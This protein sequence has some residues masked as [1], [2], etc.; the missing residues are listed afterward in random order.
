MNYFRTAI[1][2]AG[3]TALFMGV[4]YMLGGQGGMVIALV[5][6]AGMNIFSYWNSDRMVLSMYGARQVDRASA[7][8]FYGL[9]EQLAARAQLPMPRVFIIDSAQPNAFAT[10]RNPQNAAVAATT[11]LINSLSREEVA[12]VMAHELAHVKNYDT[13]T[14]TITATLAGAISM[15]ANFAMFFGGGRNN[16]NPFGLIGTIA[17]MILAP[18]AAMV[19]QMAISR[20]RE[21]EADKLGAQICGQPLWLASALAKIA[22]AAQHIPNMP[23]EH[24]PATAHMFIINPLSGERMDNLFSTHPATENRIAALQVLAQEMGG[25]MGTGWGGGGA[26]VEPEAAGSGS[27]SGPWGGASRRPGSSASQASSNVWGRTG[28]DDGGRGSGRGPW[29]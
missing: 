7:P 28:R 26:Y 3:M 14:M 27:G 29:G 21:Y 1:L 10:G 23:A 2:L 11:G 9:I 22:G 6:A 19:V 15:L 4:G 20:S 12:G 5:F 13:L 24:N 16:N 17:M 18:L 8:E 25:G